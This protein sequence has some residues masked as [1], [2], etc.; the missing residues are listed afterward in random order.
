MR[1]NPG[2]QVLSIVQGTIQIGTGH[3]AR[4][5][6]GL[7]A[8]EQEFVLSL[9]GSE[10]IKPYGPRNILGL[11]RQRAILSVLSPVLIDQPLTDALSPTPPSSASA[12]ATRNVRASHQELPTIQDLH[13]AEI[14][15][16]NSDSS[17]S[18]DEASMASLAQAPVLPRSKYRTRGTRRQETE[19]PTNSRLIPDV[20]QWS[21]AYELDASPVVARRLEARVAI[22]GLGRTGQLLA[23]VLASSGIGSLLLCDPQFM[24]P[25]DVGA[26]TTGIGSVGQLRA[27]ALASSLQR[28]FPKLI[29][30]D[31]G[32]RDADAP[33]VDLAVV[34]AGTMLPQLADLP[35]DQR[36]LPVLF[37]DAGVRIGP[38]V[39]PGMT[40]CAGCAWEQCDPTLRLVPPGGHLGHC[41]SVKPESS[42]AVTTAGSVATQVLMALDQVN[43]PT[44]AENMLII[45]LATGATSQVPARTRAGCTCMDQQAA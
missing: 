24:R 41:T 35:I 9:C 25:D 30:A 7:S 45:D 31:T 8:G 43:I 22:H 5:I 28:S 44:A 32:I 2:L 37:T 3:R 14:P 26:G 12:K 42:L 20:L 21:A 27:R 29:V 15:T 16:P 6:T 23:A 19:A 13:S 34:V 4:W 11:D 1:I 36:L 18:N 39:I 10:P 17:S 40:V 33:P 38:L